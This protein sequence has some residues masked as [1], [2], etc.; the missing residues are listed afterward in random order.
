MRKYI[1]VFLPLIIVLLFSATPVF[2][3]RKLPQTMSAVTSTTERV[4]Q[5]TKG[6]TT[7]VRFKDDRTG[8]IVQFS[9]LTSVSSVAYVFSY[10]ANGITQGASGTLTK[11]DGDPLERELL[12]GTCSAGIC[13]YDTNI[14]NAK[15]TV[16]TTLLDGTIVIKP[17]VLKL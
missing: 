1:L 8:I 7:K 14:T 12:F 17:Y 5:V 6:V 9:G 13:R 2:A 10:D 3:K 15:L 16:T 11:E 4:A